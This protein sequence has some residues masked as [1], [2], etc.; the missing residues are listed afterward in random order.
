MGL[1][2]LAVFGSPEAFSNN[3]RLTFSLRK[4]QAL[5]FYLAVE[6]GMHSRSKLAAF[7]W[8]DSAAHEARSSLRNVIALLRTLLADAGGSPS[9]SSYLHI[10]RDLVG[11]DRNIPFELDLE[12]VQHVYQEV[13]QFST[14]PPEPQRVAL[15]AKLQQAVSLVRGPFL[16]GFWLGE[17]APFDEWV[18][19]QQQQWQVRL[20]LLLNRLSCW[21]EVGGELEQAGTTITR[22]LMHD[23]LAEEA[24][25]RLMRVHLA[26]GDATAALQVYATC[27]TRLAEDLRVDPSEETVALAEH[28]RAGST[29]SSELLAAHASAERPMSGE[30]VV[31]LVGRAG[32]FRQ[33]I[34]S[35]Q[36]ARSGQPQVV[37]VEGEAGIGKTRLAVEWIGWARAQGAE[38]LRGQAYEMGGRLPYQPLMEAL[39]ERLEVEN[40]PEDLLEDVWL[41]ELS[42][43]LPEL[44]MRYPDLPAP[45]EDELTAKGRLFEA[46]AR[47][48]DSLAWHTP[49]VLL[50]EDLHWVDEASLELLSYLGH[51]WARHR[52]R[53]LLLGTLRSEEETA[54][55]S[56][57]IDLRRD[58]P[59]TQVLLQAF[60][61]EETIQFIEACVGKT[62]GRGNGQREHDLVMTLGGF[63]F[64]HAGGHPLYLLETLTL[65]RE[66]EWLL[67]RLGADST[68]RLELPVDRTMEVGLERLRCELFPP[69]VRALTQ[70]RLVRLTQPARQLVMASAVLGIQTTT[71][72]LWQVAEMASLSG[73]QITQTAITALEEA[74][75][76]GMLREEEPGRGRPATYCFAHELIRD[77]VYTEIGA[78]RRQVLHQRALALFE[79][80]GAPA[81][82][83]AYHARLAGEVEAAYRFSMQAGMEAVAVF[84][85]AD[86]IGYYEQARALLQEY[87]WLHTELTVAAIEHLYTHLGQAYA[88]QSAWE[89]AQETYKEL[90][91][92][93][94]H[95]QLPTLISLT[96]NRLAILAIQ[97]S[98]DQAQVDALLE[99]A[100]QVAE[101]SHDPKALAETEWNR[102]QI[103]ATWDNPKDALPHGTQALALARESL[104]QEL[105]ARSLSL[106]GYIH[107]LRGDFE[108]SIRCLEAS[109]TIYALWGTEPFASGELSLPSF[110][111]G[112]SLTRGVTKRATEA[113]YWAVLGFVQVHTGQVQ[114]SLLSGRKALALAQES[115]DIWA[116]II[117]T[118]SLTSSLLDTGAYE[119]ALALAQSARAKASTLP[120]TL[121]LRLFLTTLASAYQA[122][123]QWEEARSTL[124]EIMAM[125]DYDVPVLSQLCIHSAVLGAWE[126]A[127][128]YALQ[129][130]ALRKRTEQALIVLDF[131]PQYEIEAFLRA[132][133]KH[134][135]RKEVQRL[136]E[137]LGSNR[138]FRIPYLRSLALLTMW[139]GNREQAIGHLR[140]AAGLA[141]EIGLPAEQWQIQA[142]LGNLYEAGGELAQACTAFGK[143]AT[144]LQE[145]AEGINDEVLR[146]RFLAG[147]QIRPV[148]QYAQRLATHSITDTHATPSD[149]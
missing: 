14:T 19:Q 16:D 116:P 100:L 137:C 32:A 114:N 74:I 147:P 81:S 44:R 22:W 12:V 4:A 99:E 58:L 27:R 132:G 110:N 72:H 129:S 130:I 11:L 102:A 93:A 10:E 42:R 82:E 94:R 97:R 54:L 87:Q 35:F 113:F 78:A 2:R 18:Q 15:V 9:S 107:L 101:T 28:I 23:P 6:G 13:Q 26:R 75:N 90:L 65:L 141:G 59:M 142:L 140:E 61:Q 8:P 30:W 145:L 68:W 108:E 25:R 40:A 138:R 121:I 135:A 20:A 21:Q 98:F 67:P 126:Q 106:L 103:T 124:A 48:F 86:A 92:Y 53:V 34:N 127:H 5:L 69:S 7:L 89:K 29:R 118:I 46:V 31:P 149:S 120:P 62:T 131:F 111:T 1:L 64:A 117:S 36:Q 88:F 45:T 41:A 122:L 66:R 96:L 49:L 146:A 39:R 123:Q 83:L 105:E 134:Q 112:V 115:K 55:S 71:R 143:A 79:R 24:Y 57:L 17:D 50:V 109:I 3:C 80:E 38:V 37:L 77:V 76:C 52:T 73:E 70:A 119:E 60:T 85:V 133:D 139:E 47:L 95:K 43:L 104:D 33:L 136:G 84:A 148:L 144:L 128:T 125:E 91:A 63:L 56:H 51:S